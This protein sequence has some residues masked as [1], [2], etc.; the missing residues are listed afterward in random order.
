[1]YYLLYVLMLINKYVYVNSIINNMFANVTFNLLI[2][3][4]QL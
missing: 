3:G 4:K 1:M 2:S